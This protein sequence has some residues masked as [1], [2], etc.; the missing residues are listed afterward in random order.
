MENEQ[1]I[2][3]CYSGFLWDVPEGYQFP[4]KAL[5]DTDW[6]LWLRGQPNLEIHCPRSGQLKIT[7]IKPFRL[8]KP[9]RLPVALKKKFELEWKPIFAMMEEAPDLTIPAGISMLSPEFIQESFIKGTAYLK[10]RA[11]YIWALKKSKVDAW[12]I[13][14][15]CKHIKHEEWDRR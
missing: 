7:P 12:S 11:S 6:E 4:K 8:L 15:W 3:Y 14:E 13:G 5:R 2:L 1:Y 9:N 10:S